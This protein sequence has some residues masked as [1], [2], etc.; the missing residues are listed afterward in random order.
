VREIS[1]RIPRDGEEVWSLCVR[2]GDM[3]S[4]PQ[5]SLIRNKEYAARL[6]DFSGLRFGKI[7]PTD[8]DGFL[9]FSDRLFIF[10]ETKYQ[11]SPVPYGQKLA[12]ERLCDATQSDTRNSYLLLTSYDSDGD[13]DI[14]ET[15]VKQYRYQRVWHDSPE[16]TLREVIEILINKYLGDYK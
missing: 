11:N 5:G 3:Y 9:D 2:N 10:V 15:V 13:I 6:K 8:I 7:S 12:L 4:N 14:G 1:H 16:M